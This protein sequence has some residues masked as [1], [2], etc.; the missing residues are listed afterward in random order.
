MAKTNKN[1]E[2]SKDQSTNGSKDKGSKQDQRKLD[3]K[4]QEW[5]Q[6]AGT[7]KGRMS[8]DKV[9][10]VSAAAAEILIAKGVAK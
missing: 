8:K 1:V 7:G 2:E 4:H 5:V 6:V 9:Y 3:R 10:T